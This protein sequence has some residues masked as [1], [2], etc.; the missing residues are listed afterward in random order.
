MMLFGECTV[1]KRRGFG[2]WEENVA[3]L[4]CFGLFGICSVLVVKVLCLDKF[5]NLSLY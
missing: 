5:F 1:V 4:V 3:Y 2:V